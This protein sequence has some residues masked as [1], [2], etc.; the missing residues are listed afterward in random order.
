MSASQPASPR[1]PEIPGKYSGVRLHCH[2]CGILRL[3]MEE[4]HRLALCRPDSR[5]CPECGSIAEFV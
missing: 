3:T 4:L 1:L 2:K 5:R